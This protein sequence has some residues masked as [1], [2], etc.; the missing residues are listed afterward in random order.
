MDSL[1]LQSFHLSPHNGTE[2]MRRFAFIA[3]FACLLSHAGC[4][5]QPVSPPT[6][7]GGAP[8]VRVRLLEAQTSVSVRADEM[9]LPA[10]Q[11][12]GPLFPA[13]T[14]VLL[15]HDGKG[16][17][18]GD[19]AI[20]TGRELVVRSN[21]V[22]SVAVNGSAYRGTLRFVHTGGGKFDVV[23][24][25]EIDD[26]LKG[27]IAKEMLADWHVEAYKAQ[28]IVART[29]AVF[30]ARTAPAGRHWD[31]LPD[32]RS[33]VYGGLAGES[34]KARLAVDE[35]RG[36]MLAYGAPG[37]EKIFKAYFS[38][39][40]GGI[41][42]NPADAFGEPFH[43]TMIEQNVGTLCNASPR[44][45]WGPVVVHRAELTRRIKLWGKQRQR[46]EQNLVRVMRIDKR[47]QNSQGRPVQY[48]ITDASGTKYFLSGEE[49]RWAINTD[50]PKDG[51]L[52]SS[53]IEPSE[54]AGENI[55]FTGRGFGHGVGMCQWCAQTRA[56]QGKSYRDIVLQA[57][58][59]SLLVQAY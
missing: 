14:A 42:Q 30:E 6:T 35:T 20:A 52:Y 7:S 58:P 34:D 4:S 31:L 29:Y 8:V 56:V 57:Y 27:V 43:P 3:L 12:T 39:C 46:A 26:Y 54:P 1:S 48:L 25:V 50:A 5:P 40:C 13:G 28:A 16:W 9:I 36:M 51:I 17:R 22:G 55:R 49:L 2:A 37:Q 23:N 15:A 53:W 41:G 19:R 33:Q 38:A 47:A 11:S 32:Q 44:F 21:Q 45:N 10:G 18:A 24:D 59:G